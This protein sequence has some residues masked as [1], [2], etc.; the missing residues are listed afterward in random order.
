MTRAIQIDRFGGPEVVVHREL[1]IPVAD[2]LAGADL[3]RRVADIFAGLLD[4]WLTVEPSGCYGFHD[5]E[6]A[7]AAPSHRAMIGEP[8]LV[9][10]P[11][12]APAD[13]DHSLSI[14]ETYQ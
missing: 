2:H 10:N 14:L 1:P 13:I 12:G 7:L 3:Q 8:V 5:V 11:R 4:G 9:P 6:R